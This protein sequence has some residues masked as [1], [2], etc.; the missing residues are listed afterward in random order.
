MGDSQPMAIGVQNNNVVG[1][2][3]TGPRNQ[4]RTPTVVN[5]ALFP[6]LMWNNRFE[7]ALGRSV[8]RFA[9]LQLPGA[10]RR[11]AVLARLRTRSA[12]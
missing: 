8:R 12:A 2:H 11:H 3:R 10:G 9:G 4:R 5:T 7:V 6:R 1:P